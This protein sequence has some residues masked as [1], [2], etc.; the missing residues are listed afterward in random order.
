MTIGRDTDQD[1][2]QI[3]ES[4]PYFGVLSDPKFL[5]NHLDDSARQEFFESG[6]KYVRDTFARLRPLLGSER[7]KAALDFGCGVG[8]LLLPMSGI[9][10][11]ATGVDVAPEMRRIT[12]ENAKAAGITNVSLHESIEALPNDAQ[13]DWIN[14]YIVFQH[15]P[16]DRGYPL[17]RALLTRLRPGGVFSLHFTIARDRS[18]L[19][20]N[21][22]RTDLYRMDGE[23]VQ[24]LLTTRDSG[25]VRMSMFDYDLNVL[26]PTLYRHGV[27]E[28]SISHSICGGHYGVILFGRRVHWVRS[29]LC[30]PGDT[31]AFS[32]GGATQ[33]LVAGF[34]APEEWG[35]WTI[36]DTAELVLPISHKKPL[37]LVFEGHGYAGP[38]GPPQ[39]VTVEVNGREMAVWQ[40]KRGGPQ[41][42]FLPLDGAGDEMLRFKFHVASPCAPVEFGEGNDFRRLGFGLRSVR[43]EK[44]G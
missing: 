16:P 14:S 12:M 9:C 36:G 19:A 29:K 15:I 38:G 5:R 32:A 17:L 41:E 40:A 11:T 3:A 20:G 28:V 26:L 2:S 34:G 35:T 18:L 33:L 1:W 13:F 8:R 27:D 23:T 24:A 25:G 42:F 43:I 4:E 37:V 10:D 6:E 22:N 7:I 31:F 39:K 44:K 21:T 30:E